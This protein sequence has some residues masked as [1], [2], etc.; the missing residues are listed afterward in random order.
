MIRITRQNIGLKARPHIAR[1]FS[2]ENVMVMEHVRPV[3]SLASQRF[4]SLMPQSAPLRRTVGPG[5][6]AASDP[7]GR[8][9]F[10]FV[11]SGLKAGAL[12][13]RAFSPIARSEAHGEISSRLEKIGVFEKELPPTV[14]LGR[15]SPRVS[16]M[17]DE[18]RLLIVEVKIWGRFAYPVQQLAISN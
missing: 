12:G 10:G 11:F 17:I 4:A 2:P 5:L 3:R 8:S 6:N 18:Q 15:V 13:C 14:R 7:S 1:G 9:R 16:L